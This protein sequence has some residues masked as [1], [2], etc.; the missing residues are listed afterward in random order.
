M[1]NNSSLAVSTQDL[2]SHL[3]RVLPPIE[4]LTALKQLST[5]S[6]E[7]HSGCLDPACSCDTDGFRYNI[8]KQTAYCRGCMPQGGD[9]I[10]WH[11]KINGM[12]RPS[13]LLALYPMDTEG[14]GEV[15]H[16]EEGVQHHVE[17]RVRHN[18]ERQPDSI[19]TR[20]N[21]LLKNEDTEPLLTLLIDRR[22]LSEETVQKAF[23]DEKI[24]YAEHAGK[25]SMA[26]PFY[27]LQGEINGPSVQIFALQFITID[28]EPFTFTI[29]PD[30]GKGKNKV[31]MKGS[32]HDDGFF[33][34]G[35]S[36]KDVLRDHGKVAIVEGVIDALTGAQVAPEIHWL[37]TGSTAYT[38]KINYLKQYL[39]SL[40]RII[41]FQDNDKTATDF[42]HKVSSIL[43]APGKIYFVAWNEAYQKGYDIND[44][45]KSG[46]EER[47]SEMIRGAMPVPA[48]AVNEDAQVDEKEPLPLQREID[49]SI[50]YPLDALGDI[51]GGAAKVMREVIQ[52]PDALCAHSIL[53]FATHSVQ[54]HANIVVDGRIIPLNESFLS[55]GDR[56]ARKSE[57]DSKAGKIHKERQKEL[58]EKYN[59]DYTAFKDEKE[60]Y[61]KA[62]KSIIESQKKTIAEKNAA[63]EELRS[64]LPH[65]PYIP[66]ELFSDPTVEG[67]HNLFLNGTP[68]KILCA[69]EGGQVSGGHSMSEE[70]KVYTSTTLSKW[71]DS[72]PIDRVRGGDGASIL[73]GRRL[74]L[75][76]MMQGGIATSFFNDS[77]M[78]N[79]G[80]MSRFLIAYPK[81]LTG[82]RKYKA[83]DITKTSAMKAF[84]EQIEINLDQE[85]PLKKSNNGEQINE[86]E[87]RNI[88]LE[89]DAKK[90]WV[91]AYEEI[92]A[93]SGKGR[94]FESIEG[95]A[96]KASNHILRLAGVIALFEDIKRATIEKSHLIKAITLMEYYLTERL[97][98][99]S[100]A[101]PDADLMDAEKL[102]E[103]IKSKR[104]KVVTLSDVYQNGPG[105]F[106]S[107]AQAEKTIK[108]LYSHYWLKRL[109]KGKSEISGKTSVDIWEVKHAKI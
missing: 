4:S 68:S 72:A 78:R 37:A 98:I 56:S 41:I 83:V 17:K 18:G 39:N 65:C 20:W 10:D 43:K 14:A 63:L 25:S 70:K 77:I 33:Q 102:L 93:A 96:G 104:L 29:D 12:T 87:P 36:F 5:N 69:D 84:Y 1:Y 89:D 95:F 107:K 19:C 66:I 24:R 8:E 59:T 76:L 23:N 109:E 32:N 85:L 15:R 79:Q 35:A 30:T 11:L 75:H 82:S 49:N 74:T 53:G 50:D 9:I 57:C 73:Y 28:G 60:V 7:L 103:W 99:M 55:V 67:I 81:P 92:E 88:T 6:K 22:K 48:D 62:R 27:S 86:L 13:E 2:I 101:A 100:M 94:M 71:W 31:F 64:N 38:K 45:L 52:A 46:Q 21:N 90:I 42:V 16:D 3:K 91:Q 97:R 105:R 108:T 58:I 44:L 61:D 54:G 51:M 34:A 26:V 80:L 106:R 47:I 40:E